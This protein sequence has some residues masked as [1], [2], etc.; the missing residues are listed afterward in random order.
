MQHAVKVS[1]IIKALN[2]E[3]NIEGAIESSLAAVAPFKGEVILA[4][5]GS[6]DKTVER[7]M[8]FPITIVQLTRTNERCCGIGPQ[9]GYQQSSGEYVYILDGDMKLDPSFLVYA[10][11]FLDREPLCA[12]VGGF[13]REMR[14]ENLEFEARVRRFNEQRAK[15][16]VDVPCLSGGG[17]YRRAAVEQVGYISD[18]NLHGY[19]EYELGARLRAKGWRLVRSDIHAADHYS[20]AVGTLRL[21]LYRIRAGYILSSGELLRAAMA[22]HYVKKVFSELRAM[23]IAIGVWVYWALVLL[24]FALIPTNWALYFLLVALLLPMVGMAI[25]TRSL[26]LGSYSVLLWHVNAIGLVFGF[27][28][29]RTAP[30]KRIDTRTIR[31]AGSGQQS[32]LPLD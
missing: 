14:I 29:S 7:A 31:V 13:V 5:S 12:G 25:R 27:F 20:H 19:E 6:T 24:I 18:R 17:L 28:R 30:A 22:N 16:T 8:K 23:R 2:E 26:L 11:E 21:L 15:E 3:S 32:E 4:D 10:I 1:V 9:L